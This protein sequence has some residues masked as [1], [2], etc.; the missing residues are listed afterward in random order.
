LDDLKT[1]H[2][3]LTPAPLQPLQQRVQAET[4]S[5]LL[6]GDNTLLREAHDRLV[7]A[8]Q[9]HA[10]K[11]ELAAEI[12]EM[13][14]QLT[15]TIDSEHRAHRDA[16]NAKL[17]AF[18]KDHA[19]H[20]KLAVIAYYECIVMCRQLGINPHQY[21]GVF[22]AAVARP[23]GWSGSVSDILLAPGGMLPWLKEELALRDKQPP[24]LK[25]A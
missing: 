17:E 18:R 1:Q 15:Q 16:M 13:Q 10:H 24:S 11:R 4:T 8:Q 2:L 5:A 21:L 23:V 19:H 6:S 9:G 3:L 20:V 22:D 14:R 25:V 12:E 7:A